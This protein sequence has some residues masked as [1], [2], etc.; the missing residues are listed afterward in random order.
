MAKFEK[1]SEDA[2]KF[3]EEVRE[4]TTIPQWIEFR[5]LCN[6][7]QKI[8]VDVKK[9]SD[10]VEVLTEGVNFAVIFNEEIF[11]QLPDDMK[12]IAVVEKLAGVSVDDNDKIS[13][14][15]EDFNTYTGVL[16]KYGDAPIIRFKES[17]K[18]LYD[19]KKQE[20][21]EAKAAKKGKRGKK[22]ID[23]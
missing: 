4:K 13:L 17:V 1:A 20:E 15:K 11:D 22:K 16:Q 5:V 12:E 6:N 14:V 18:S 9:N 21:D 7:K 8:P 10:L 19:K 23:V 2:E 3:F